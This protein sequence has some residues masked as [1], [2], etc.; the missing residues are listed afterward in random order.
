MKIIALIN[1]KGG[2]GKTTCAINIGAGLNKLNKR[3][4]LIDLDPQAHLTYSL[5]IP[6]H[7]QKNTVYELLKNKI[8]AKKTIINRN[9][10][11][12]IPSSLNLSGAE[13]EFSGIAGREFLLRESLEGIKKYDYVLI[14]CPPSLGLLTLNALTT[15]QE[16]YIPLQTEFL[17]LQGMSK[18]L[19]TINIVKKRLNKNIEIAGIIATRFDHRKNLNK[20]VVEKIENYFGNRLFNT[21][22][23]DNVSLAE[24]PSFGQTIFEYKSNS[25]GSKDYLSLCKEIVKRG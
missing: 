23:R 5:G 25:Y 22:I 8:K 7:E 4:L 14:D 10:I 13:I 16:I 12:L 18:L 15:A 20:E 1:Q 19:E 3:V 21:F 11:D 9:G 24:A 6:A 17:A 2:V